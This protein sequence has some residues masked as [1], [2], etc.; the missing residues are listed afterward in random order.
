MNK[1]NCPDCTSIY[2]LLSIEEREQIAEWR[3][4]KLEK[5]QKEIK[6]CEEK[7]NSIKES[8]KAKL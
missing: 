2:D 4:T 1:S 7:I 6:K 8:Q 5:Q 3:R